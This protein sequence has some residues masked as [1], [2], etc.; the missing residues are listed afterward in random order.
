YFDKLD[1]YKLRTKGCKRPYYEFDGQWVKL[2]KK[3]VWLKVGLGKHHNFVLPVRKMTYWSKYGCTVKSDKS[4]QFYAIRFPA[5]MTIKTG[6]QLYEMNKAKNYNDFW[7]ALRIHAISLFN[8]VYADK[9]NNIFYLENGMMPQRDTS[10]N[11]S[12]IL[13]GNTSKTLWTN[14]VP[15]DSMPHTIDP[16]CGYVFNTNNT[17]FHASGEDCY[18]GYCHLPKYVDERPGDNNRAHRFM[19]QIGMKNKFSIP[20]LKKLKFDVSFTKAGKFG[21][22][23]Q[24]LVNLDEHKYPDLK[25]ALDILK[26]WDWKAEINEYAPPLVFLTMTE[27]FTNHGC[28]D[29]CFISGVNATEAEYV[30]GLRNACDSLRKYYGTVKVEWGTIQRSIRGDKNLPVRGMPDVLSPTY[31]ERVPGT[32]TFKPAYGDTYTMFAVFGKDGL[33]HLEALQP[34]GNSLNQQSPHYNDQMELFS[35]QQTRPLSLKQ[36]DVMKRAERI[37]NPL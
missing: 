6:E 9:D 13:P 14:L 12:G 16:D 24:E 10:F 11:W 20:D 35:R 31:P 5:N 2:E 36:S 27:V 22:N 30:A 18:D 23:L 15:I 28:S 33:E 25:E 1:V 4:N 32:F 37:Y 8:I 21:A 26:A 3:P 19:E 29:D 17:P 7:K 34:L